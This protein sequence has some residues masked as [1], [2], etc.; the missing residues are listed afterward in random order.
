M[1]TT[2][3]PEPSTSPDAEH[4]AVRLFVLTLLGVGTFTAM[5]LLL[6]FVVP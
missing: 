3:T 4:F 6:T 2:H 5:S 1:Q